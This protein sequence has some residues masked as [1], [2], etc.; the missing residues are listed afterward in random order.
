MKRTI[1]EAHAYCSCR[2]VY[3]PLLPLRRNLRDARTVTAHMPPSNTPAVQYTSLP[4]ASAAEGN[5][6]DE[7][8][9]T[10]RAVGP[11]TTSRSH[12]ARPTD[13][14]VDADPAD[15]AGHRRTY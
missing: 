3:R 6:R 15:H 8:R 12:N 9:G 13:C 1:G 4:Q 11:R 5:W 10:V 7:R 14:R 2:F